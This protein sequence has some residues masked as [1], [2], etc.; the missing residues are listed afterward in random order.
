M[1]H[2]SHKSIPDASI[3]SG[4]LFSFGD[5]ASQNFAVETVI[6]FG[7][8]PHENG[9]NFEKI[10]FYVQIRSFRLKVGP[11]CQFHQFSS[12]GKF[13]AFKIFRTSR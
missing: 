8:L 11:L 3:E 1:S 5:M 6:K 2:C 7:Y 13:F 10:S 4:S 12:R 9:F